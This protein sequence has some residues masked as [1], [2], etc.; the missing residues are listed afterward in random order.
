MS[1]HMWLG[2]R[3]RALEATPAKWEGEAR[4]EVSLWGV[5]VAYC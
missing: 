2:A 1:A 3:I 5:L 4:V